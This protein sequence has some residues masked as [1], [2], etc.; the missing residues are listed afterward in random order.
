[1]N[2]ELKHAFKIYD[3][4]IGRSFPNT[5]TSQMLELIGRCQE[6]PICGKDVQDSCDMNRASAN[7]LLTKLCRAG[8]VQRAEAQSH[9]SC[10]ELTDKALGVISK[11]EMAVGS[12]PNHGVN[13]PR[14]RLDELEAALAGKIKA[15][16]AKG[17]GR[18]E[19]RN[20]TLP[21]K[22]PSVAS[23]RTTQYLR[24]LPLPGLNN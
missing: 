18:A 14:I 20:S 16:S 9:E 3:E 5:P 17:I 24:Q 19:E 1:M 2:Y 10:Y 7:K 22:R 8:L 11:L 6:H 13:A 21:P 4:N 12:S 15:L 23:K